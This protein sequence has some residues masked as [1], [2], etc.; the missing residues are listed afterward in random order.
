MDY[1]SDAGFGVIIV[2]WFDN[3]V[4]HIAS[5]YVGVEPMGIVERWSQ[6][7]QKKKNIQ[8]PQ[9]V[10]QYNKGMGG[11][12]LADMPISLYRIKIKTRRWYIKIFW[13]L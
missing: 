13:H 6:K 5:T 1:K 4:V 9:L 7:D 11:V 10:L 3:N 2:K 12:D 8:C